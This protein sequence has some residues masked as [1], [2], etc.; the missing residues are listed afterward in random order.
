MDPIQRSKYLQNMGI[1]EW[2]SR[3]T[4]ASQVVEL[5]S[6]NKTSQENSEELEKTA[7]PSSVSESDWE[8]L[9]KT[10]KSCTACELH[11]TRTQTVFG[12]GNQNADLLIIGEAPGANEDKQGLPFVGRAGQLLDGC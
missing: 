3:D 5:S 10:V 1:Q 4:S 7:Q 8:G 9:E 2:K 6:N 12:V 11:C